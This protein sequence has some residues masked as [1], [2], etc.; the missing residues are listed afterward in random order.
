LKNDPEN[1][2]ALFRRAQAYINEGNTTRARE[3]LEKLT[4]KNP[5]GKSCEIYLFIIMIII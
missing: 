4:A 3:D 1:T 2:K 5:D